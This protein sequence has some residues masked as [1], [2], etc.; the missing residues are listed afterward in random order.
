M[1]PFAAADS[2]F[3]DSM[4]TKSEFRIFTENI[5]MRPSVFCSRTIPIPSPNSC[6]MNSRT[7]ILRSAGTRT[8]D[9]SVF[10]FS[11]L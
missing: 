10:R 9:S 1:N 5:P 11:E 6:R 4:I 7:F 8:A 3:T 2:A